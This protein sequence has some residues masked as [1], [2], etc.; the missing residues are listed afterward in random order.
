[1]KRAGRWIVAAAI[2]ASGCDAAAKPAEGNT[3]TVAENQPAPGVVDSILPMREHIR[4]FQATVDSKP[5]MLE[6]GAASRDELVT[7]YVKALE[8]RDAA[9]LRALLVT[10]AE[11]AYFYYPE[12]MYTR[13]PYEL[14]P[15]IVWLQLEHGTST[16]STRAL[17]RIGGKPLELQRYECPR[18]ATMEGSNRLW[19]D[20][21]VRIGFADAQ[22]ARLFG[23]IIER[24]GVFKFLSY[25]NPL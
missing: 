6:G 15:D 13:K 21:L 11:F 20:C 1:M 19:N 9:E 10:R 8:A 7:R 4:R 2:L 23:S 24:G 25:A 16:G 12:S 14:S 17:Q 3:G 22:P 18:G 5:K